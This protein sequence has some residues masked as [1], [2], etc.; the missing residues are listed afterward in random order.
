MPSIDLD[1][2][3]KELDGERKNALI[4]TEEQE[5]VIRYGRETEPKV[6][7]PKLAAKLKKY[8]PEI[9]LTPDKLQHYCSKFGIGYD[10]SNP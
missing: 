3:F 6:S 10:K 8:W 2:I 4:F 7:Y 5:K 9:E 1:E